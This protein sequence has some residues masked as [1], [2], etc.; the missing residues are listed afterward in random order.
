MKS[1]ALRAPLERS[2]ST[3]QAKMGVSPKKGFWGRRKSG[4]LGNSQKSLKTAPSP[5][6]EAALELRDLSKPQPQQAG[7]VSEQEADAY[8]AEG[9]PSNAL[10]H[11]GGDEKASTCGQPTLTAAEREE[12]HSAAALPPFQQAASGAAGAAGHANAA[13]GTSKIRSDEGKTVD[14][15]RHSGVD[16]GTS[17]ERSTA[18]EEPSLA[19]AEDVCPVGGAAELGFGAESDCGRSEERAV[20]Q[21]SIGPWQ[22]GWPWR[23]SFGS[24]KHKSTA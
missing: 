3:K 23:L 6:E 10:S 13:R 18:G 7:D 9:A 4:R 1:T 22:L 24:C 17:T 14:I 2:P 19:A 5:G 16:I 20:A 8:T 15:V 12:G 21:A 11:I